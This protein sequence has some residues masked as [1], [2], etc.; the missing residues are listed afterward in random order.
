M[1]SNC[2]SKIHEYYLNVLA[3]Q[4]VNQQGDCPCVSSDT[5]PLGNVFTN[6]AAVLTTTFSFEQF[7]E[8]MDFR[9]YHRLPGWWRLTEFRVVFTKCEP[10]QYYSYK[11]R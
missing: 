5:F 8:L 7:S 1:R 2:C 11:I 10:W 6:C 3:T 9:D 4:W